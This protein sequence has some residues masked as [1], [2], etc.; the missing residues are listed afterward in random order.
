M[1][2]ISYFFI[3]YFSGIESSTC[4]PINITQAKSGVIKGQ[5]IWKLTL[6][7]TCACNLFQVKLNIPN[8]NSVTKINTNIITKDHNDIYIVNKGFNIY[9][10]SNVFFTYAGQSLDVTLNNQYVACS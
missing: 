1:F 4:N 5:Q 7:N 9:A 2:L 10:Q 6:T 3:F 8:F